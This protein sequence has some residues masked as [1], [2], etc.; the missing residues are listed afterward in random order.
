[1]ASSQLMKGRLDYEDIR[2]GMNLMQTVYT[3]A[4]VF[5]VE[6]VVEASYGVL[7]SR[8]LVRRSASLE[9]ALCLLLLAIV[10]LSMRFFWVPRNINSYIVNWFDELQEKVFSRVTMIHFPIALLHAVLFYYLCQ[11]F[12][13]M[14]AAGPEVESRAMA[15]HAARF[16]LLYASLLLLNAVWLFWITPRRT[17]QR[18]PGGIWAYNNIG[19]F[20]LVIVAFAVCRSAGLPNLLLILL[21]CALFIANSVIDLALAAKY[22]ILYEDQ[23]R[24]G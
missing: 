10:L 24:G 12:V 8:E 4:M 2:S 6:K 11:A 15:Y 13:D 5:G 9:L 17:R 23:S 14:V 18:S 21:A 16:V 1:M 22:Y 20:V 19:F 3:V 7:I